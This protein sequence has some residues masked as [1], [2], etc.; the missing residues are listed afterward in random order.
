MIVNIQYVQTTSSK[1][2]VKSYVRS[3][4]KDNQSIGFVPTMGALHDGH[5]ALV[6]KAKAECDRV[7]VSIFVNPIQFTNATDFDRYPRTL[8]EDQ[9]KLM[10]E[11]VDLVFA[12]NAEE[13]YATKPLLSLDF[14]QVGMYLEGEYRPGH[15]SGAGIVVARLFHIVEP[16]K[17]FFGLK[18]LQQVAIIRQLITDLAFDVQL[19]PCPTERAENG[20]ALSSRNELLSTQGKELASH[21]FKSLKKAAELFEIR[22]IEESIEG[23][24]AY[25]ADFP[26]IELEY[27]EW[28]DA[29]NMQPASHKKDMRQPAVCIAA[30]V[31]GI[32]L[33]DNL[34]L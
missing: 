12:P 31:E 4:K 25:L 22:S 1:S 16:D 9:T 30:R 18:D 29:L 23:A 10:K 34:V 11:G 7:V 6:R 32:R 3:W 20:L 33:I 26:G 28:V 19:V 15:F 8:R 2:I 27:L 13:F 17:A 24:K 21:L 5:L 14:G